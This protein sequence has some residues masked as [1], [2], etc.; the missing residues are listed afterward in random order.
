[1][2]DRLSVACTPKGV[3]G[4]D[5]D[6]LCPTSSFVITEN[7]LLHFFRLTIETKLHVFSPVVELVKRSDPLVYSR[8]ETNPLI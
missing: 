7:R 2:M 3:M 6:K 5:D 1:M 8:N 4:S